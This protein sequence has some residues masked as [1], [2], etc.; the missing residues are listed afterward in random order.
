MKVDYVIPTYNSA[1]CL[2]KCLVAVKKYGNPHNIF[3]IDKFSE[4]ETLKIAQ[5]HHCK[6]I[7]TN[8]TLG[9]CRIIG[10][11]K[12]ETDWIA[13]VDSDIIINKDW[14]KMFNY[15]DNKSIGAIQIKSEEKNPDRPYFLSPNP[16]SSRFTRGFTGATLIRRNLVLDAPIEDCQAFEDWFLS[17]HIIKKGYQWLVTL[18]SPEDHLHIAEHDKSGEAVIWHSQSWFRYYKNKKISLF[19][20]LVFFLR[21]TIGFLIKGKFKLAYYFLIGPFK[22]EYFAMKRKPLKKKEENTNNEYSS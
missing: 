22:P 9:K 16:F 19:T 8:A 17:K 20:F 18:I 21:H 7:Q 3:I 2:D 12:A 11:Q 15:C 1:Y 6:I 14:Q 5:A 4:D 10:A 13:F